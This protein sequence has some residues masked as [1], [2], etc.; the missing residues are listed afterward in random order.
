[1]L[2]GEPPFKGPTPQVTLMLRFMGPP[3]AL[4][5]MVPIPEHVEAAIVR[6]LA[7]DPADRYANAA[8]F[9]DALA[10]RETPLATPPAPSGASSSAKKGC[11]AMIILAAGAAGIVESLLW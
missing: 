2:A 9:A 5:P 4:R 8:E 10:G 3:R 6:A 11:A 1:V 7:K